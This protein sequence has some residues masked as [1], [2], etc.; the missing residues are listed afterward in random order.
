MLPC[1]RNDV[2]D[3]LAGIEMADHVGPFAGAVTATVQERV[4]LERHSTGTTS[5]SARLLLQAQRSASADGRRAVG[6]TP[7]I[8]RRPAGDANEKT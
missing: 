1:E 8:T 6:C 4:Q 7:V 5:T 3:M 2:I